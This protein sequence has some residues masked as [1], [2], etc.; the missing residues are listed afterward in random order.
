MW[1]SNQRTAQFSI[2][3]NNW[4]LNFNLSLMR[5][6]SEDKFEVFI[7]PTF[8]TIITIRSF[9]FCICKVGRVG[10]STAL[11]P[12]ILNPPGAY[13]TC[14]NLSILLLVAK[15]W[16][17]LIKVLQIINSSKTSGCRWR[18]SRASQSFRSKFCRLTTLPRGGFGKWLFSGLLQ[19]LW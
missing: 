8:T 18:V 10:W 3:V 11:R 17:Q 1:D 5:Y 2:N 13:R 7:I 12:T 4:I 9:S 19:A 15:R 6:F 16:L 14:L